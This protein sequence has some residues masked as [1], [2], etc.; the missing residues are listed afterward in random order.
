MGAMLKWTRPL[1]FWPPVALLLVALTAS[2]IDFESFHARVTDANNWILS[3]FDWMFSY[4]SFVAVLLLLW[5]FVS[6]LGKVRIGGAEAKP[7]LKRWN[8]F[9]ITLCTTIATGILFWGTAEPMFHVN[10]PPDFSGVDARS[11]WGVAFCSIINVYA[12]DDHTI[13]NLFGASAG[14]CLGAL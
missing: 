4:A 7:I 9:A 6:P 5:V 12:L 8:W 13:C 1:V 2:L 3:R 11:E 14:F 10:S